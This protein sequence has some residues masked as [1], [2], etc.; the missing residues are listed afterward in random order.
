M[1]KLSKNDIIEIAKIKGLTIIN[2]DEYIN[3]ESSNLVFECKDGHTFIGDLKSVRDNKSFYCPLCDRQEVKY[4]SKPPV[5]NGFRIIGFDQATQNFGI[6]VYDDEKLV[7]YD[8]AKF[9]GETEDRLVSIANFIDAVCKE[10]QPDFVIFEDIQL[11]QNHYG[12]FNT[13]KVLAELMGVVKMILTKNKV[14]HQCV[15]NKV[16]QAYFNISGKDR[17]SQTL[18]VVAR[19]NDLFGIK[20]VDDIADAILIGKYGCTLLNKAPS[21]KLF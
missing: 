3:L 8:V 4:V 20:V 14:K 17:I 5:K 9:G 16:W 1:A 2:P 12:G 10:W 15:L 7:Y 11:Q 18:M 21:K 13:F 6:S 19:V